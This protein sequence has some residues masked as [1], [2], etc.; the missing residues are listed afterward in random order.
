M[1]VPARREP[2][3]QKS[4]I[5]RLDPKI[6]AICLRTAKL[7]GIGYTRKEIAQAVADEL[8][9]HRD[10]HRSEK[11][12]MAQRKIRAWEKKQWFRDLVWDAAVVELD[13]SSGQILRGIKNKAKR[14]RV[15]AAK[16]ALAITGRHNEK[17]QAVPAA[18]TINLVGVPRPARNEVRENEAVGLAEVTAEEYED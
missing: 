7:F 10:W 13:M 3:T 14:G 8:Y 15:D 12:S 11:V 5:D 2:E 4:G 16:L 17:E 18:V 1:A 9:G 6:G